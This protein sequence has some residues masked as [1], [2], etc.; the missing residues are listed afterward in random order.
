MA[1]ARAA[2]AAAEG[3]VVDAAVE[4][5]KSASSRSAS[6]RAVLATPARHQHRDGRHQHRR[7]RRAFGDERL[8]AV[9]TVQCTCSV[10]MRIGRRQSMVVI[11]AWMLVIY[12]HRI[13]PS[14]NAGRAPTARSA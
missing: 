11:A 12:L 1:A 3:E 2:E 4:E 7:R 5:G 8:H 9:S 14:N 10:F 13:P 6:A